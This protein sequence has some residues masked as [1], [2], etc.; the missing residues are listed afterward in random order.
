[1]VF[2]VCVIFLLGLDCAPNILITSLNNLDKII[3]IMITIM[4]VSTIEWKD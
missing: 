2:Y 1:M 4:I 3:A